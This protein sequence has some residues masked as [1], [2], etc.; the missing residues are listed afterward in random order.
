MMLACPPAALLP[1]VFLTRPNQVTVTP[2]DKSWPL[3]LPFFFIPSP[4]PMHVL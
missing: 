4:N 1:F 2:V 3:P